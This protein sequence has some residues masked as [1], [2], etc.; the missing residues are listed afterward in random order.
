MKHFSFSKESFDFGWGCSEY[1]TI[2][3]L[4]S[5]ILFLCGYLTTLFYISGISYVIFYA[6]YFVFL[7]GFI[8]ILSGIIYDSS[9]AHY[10]HWFI[11]LLFLS[12]LSHHNP[13][14]S[15]IHGIFFGVFI[16]GC[17]RY[18]L[19]PVWSEIDLPDKLTDIR[20]NLRSE[21]GKDFILIK[22][23]INNLF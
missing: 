6:I 7:F 16:E 17:S 19:D 1:T 12:F 14:I 18:G 15:G 22:R 10:H 5:F 13:L 20:Q 9:E 2:S 23:T 8:S 3:I 21:I 4:V 11:S